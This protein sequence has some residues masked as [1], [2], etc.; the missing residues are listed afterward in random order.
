M[1]TE[2]K[3]IGENGL[4]YFWQKIKNAIPTKTSELTNDSKFLTSVPSNYLD[5]NN[6]GT[7]ILSG[8]LQIGTYSTNVV[9]AILHIRNVG[10]GSI[11][12]AKVNG[13]CYSVNAD[14]TATLQHK[15]YDDKGGNA[16]NMAVL[17]MSN[18]GI[19]FA[20][21]TGTTNVPT[22]DMY[23]NVVT[24]DVL[25]TYIDALEKRIEELEKKIQ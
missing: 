25:L 4:L 17:R 24:E 16:R 11:T 2:K 10:T 5:K 9:N 3:F 21:N 18:K 7:H 14:G 19:Q 15:T 6:T 1:S 13:A 20:V 22:E 23:H 12:G 8:K